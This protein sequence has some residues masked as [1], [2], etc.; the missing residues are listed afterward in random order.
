MISPSEIKELQRK[1]AMQ[2]TG[3][4]IEIIHSSTTNIV[5]EIQTTLKA[6]VPIVGD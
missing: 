4:K 5:S 2:I 6:M 1:I 3:S